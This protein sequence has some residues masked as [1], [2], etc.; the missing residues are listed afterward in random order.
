[1]F[2]WLSKSRLSAPASARRTPRRVR[3]RKLQF[4]QLEDRTVPTTV[5]ASGIAFSTTSLT[6]TGVG[7]ANFSVQGAGEPAANF[8]ASIDWGDSSTPS[9]ADA[10]KYA[11]SG[12]DQ[13]VVRGSHTYAQT[14]NYSIT[15]AIQHQSESPVTATTVGRIGTGQFAYV[16]SNHGNSILAIDRAGNVSTFANT[17]PS[18]APY[19]PT[20]VAVDAQGN[21]YVSNEYANTVEEFSPSGQDMGVFAAGLHVPTGLAF[22]GQGNLYVANN[23][24]GVVEKFSPGGQDLGVFAIDAIGIA[25][26]TID[27]QGNLFLCNEYAPSTSW[28]KE[29]SPSGQLLRTFT[30]GLVQPTDSCFDS[31]GNLY[32]LNYGGGKIV[33]FAPSGQF[34]GVFATSSVS[35][36]FDGL[37]FDAAGNLYACEYS[38]GRIEEFDSNG[39]SLGF[40]ASGLSGPDFITFGAAP[41]ANLAPNTS[42]SV[43]SS[44]P[45][46]TS[47]YGDR[48]TFTAA[49]TNTSGS[50][51]PL[52]DVEFFD[53]VT[54][55]GP[56]TFGSSSGNSTSWTLTTSA[57]SAGSHNIQ[58][59]FTS[60]FDFN[61]SGAGMSQ[62]V[63]PRVLN[64][65][66]TASDKVYD[67]T[68]TVAVNYSDDALAGDS[69]TLSYSASFPD[70][71][72][73]TGKV[74]T[75]TGIGINGG[76]SLDYV[77]AT[78][79]AATTASITPRPLTVTAL[80]MDKVYD[81]TTA[82]GVALSDDRVS[83]DDLA[84]HYGS[85][86]FVDAN[87][88]V[89]KTINVAGI[90]MSG[91]DSGNYSLQNTS[92][93][94]TANITAAGVAISITPYSVAY[95]G[96][97]HT[98][99]GTATGVG[100]VSLGGLD[101]SGT[102]HTA[103]GTYTDSW[104]FTDPSGNYASAGGTIADRIVQAGT[105]VTLTSSLNSSVPGQSVTFTATVINT[106][107]SPVPTGTVTFTDTTTYTVLASDVALDNAGQASISTSALGVGSHTITA[108]YA[109]AAGNFVGGTSSSTSE[110]VNPVAN[111]SLS[112]VVWKDFNNDGQ[113]DFGENGIA[114]VTI[115][116]TGTDDQGNAVNRGLTTDADGAY[117]FPNLGSGSY[118]LTET[119]PAGFLPG[120]ASIGTAGGS[121]AADNEFFVQ[122][123]QGANGLNYN[124]GELPATTGAVQ[125]G[126]T[127][128]I[129]F[130]NNKN[131]Q[132]LIKSLN[133][134][135]TSAELGNWLAA[136][137]PHVFGAEAGGNNLTDKTNAD[138]AALFQQDFVLKGVK[139][140]AQVLAT[141]LSVYATNATLDSTATAA[142]YGFIVSGDGVGTATFNVGTNGNAFGVPDNATMSILDLLQ[143]TD[144]QSVDGLLYDGNV[145]L[146][147][148]ANNVYSAI[149][150]AGTIN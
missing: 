111:G 5:T 96:D 8:S 10:I 52:G 3:P 56:G 90:S 45:A 93:T 50:A 115:T 54:D 34:L 106:S 55:L 117:V 9:Q 39:Q 112:G 142:P 23:A 2:R 109:N 143:A 58:A 131:G 92:A 70:K 76:S 116:L 126:Q 66:L 144:S 22:D 27:G 74:V 35:N 130:W 46:G 63:D 108:V 149:N 67:G 147:Q 101:L 41:G 121:V 26:L 113:V 38:Q 64:V 145:T 104:T 97:S 110:T 138:V 99:T 125:K 134:G 137:L 53:G 78:T 127:A 85:A 51:A 81:G 102:A 6:C 16:T 28:V 57:L 47:I 118:N 75:I 30:D 24:N 100:G 42:T 44:A 40:F 114:G 11:S 146:R 132:A 84:D 86:D 91:A 12:M 105:S 7:V 80:G 148:E 14:G 122:L 32:V 65:N 68:D 69:V 94:A 15:V 98:A 83:G 107:T 135:P 62:T 21:V 89:S 128:G 48:V 59:V 20:G 49:V 19:G 43:T 123:A 103:A 139:L 33:R 73:G 140:D 71:N 37:A 120:V 36:P 29:Y 95:D 60:P 31:Q 61:V 133:G 119:P 136:T 87:V 77:L 129:G 82:A 72:V 88:G 25:G 18:N 79:T 4:E 1:M 150:Q 13:Y 124:F 17:T 141:A